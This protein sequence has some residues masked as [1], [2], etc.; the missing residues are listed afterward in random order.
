MFVLPRPTPTN[1]CCVG[2]RQDGRPREWPIISRC[3]NWTSISSRA[4]STRSGS[5]I[6]AGVTPFSNRARRNLSRHGFLNYHYYFRA[7]RRSLTPRS[8]VHSSLPP[9]SSVIGQSTVSEGSGPD[10]PWSSVL[11]PVR[12]W[13]SY[14]VYRSR[15]QGGS[16]HVLNIFLRS[17]RTSLIPRTSRVRSFE[18]SRTIR[19]R[20][21]RGRRGGIGESSTHV[22]VG[23][24][25]APSGMSFRLLCEDT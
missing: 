9:S 3:K 8:R 5:P 17:I 21:C 19:V 23:T 10:R 18:T 2:W 24:Y 1:H 12:E 7:A 6:S 25:P 13:R 15:H 14:P 20:E 16:S 22:R 4:R 11:P